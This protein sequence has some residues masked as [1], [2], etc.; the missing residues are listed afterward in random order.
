M[1]NI[2]N[3]RYRISLEDPTEV[4]NDIGG[5]VVTYVKTAD[6][7][8]YRKHRSGNRNFNGVIEVNLDRFE[9]FIGKFHPVTDKTRVVDN[10]KSFAITAIEETF[11]HIKIICENS[12]SQVFNK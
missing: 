1:K 2:G 10:G 4:K 7:W 5:T 3:A 6:V 12:P 11:E 9:Y 8:A